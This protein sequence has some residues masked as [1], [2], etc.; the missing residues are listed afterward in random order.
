MRRKIII[1]L[2]T[3]ILLSVLSTVGYMYIQHLKR[4]FTYTQQDWLNYRIA[5]LNVKA[6]NPRKKNVP[7]FLEGLYDKNDQIRRISLKG[8]AGFNQSEKIKEEIH[9]KLLEFMED[10]NES[11]KTF[12]SMAAYVCYKKFPG[13]KTKDSFKKMIYMLPDTSF[14]YF[15]GCFYLYVF[16]GQ[17]DF[18]NETERIIEES[19]EKSRTK[20]LKWIILLSH[21]DFIPVIKKYYLTDQQPELI[22]KQAEESIEYIEKNH[23]RLWPDSNPQKK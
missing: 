7:E 19:P 4:I 5:K 2:I 20:Y 8:L 1:F 14:K 11:D 6:E 22:K 16:T 9:D 15:L 10:D 17:K 12:F 18:F 23:N 3:V 21:K 13:E